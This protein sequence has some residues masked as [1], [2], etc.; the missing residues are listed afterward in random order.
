MNLRPTWQCFGTDNDLQHP[1]EVAVV[2]PTVGRDTILDAV[3]SVYAQRGVSRI[4]LL[5]GVDVAQGDFMRLQE[6]LEAAPTHVTPCLFSPGYSTSSRH[7]GLHPAHDGGT[8]RTV[9]SYLANARHVAYLDDDN[10]WAPNHLR[11]MLDAIR[12]RDWAFALRWFVHPESRQP[13]CVDDWESVGPDR[14]DYAPRFGGW[15]DPN[16]L[17]ID[18]LACEPVLRWWDVPLPGDQSQLSSDRHVFDWLRRKGAPG[19][20]GQPTVYYVMQA[21]DGM[22]P[23]RLAHMGSRY[24]EAGIGTQR[25][26][27]PRL[28]MIT[29]CKGRLRHLQQTLP[30]M[31]CQPLTEVVVVDYGCP[32]GTAAW[33]RANFPAVR[34]VEVTDDPGF[35][36]SRARNI[37]ARTAMTPWLLFVD[38]DVIVGA[39]LGEWIRA[40]LVPGNF[41]LTQ[42]FGRSDLSG[43]FFCP[44]KAFEAVGG[45]DEAITGWGGED[46][47]LYIRLKTSGCLLNS[48][49]DG[50]F[51]AISHGD[52]ERLAYTSA[53]RQ[54][55]HVIQHWYSSMKYDLTALW[56]REPTLNERTK[57][58]RLAEGAVRKA[59]DGELDT[60]EVFLQLGENT[61]ATRLAVLKLERRLIYKLAP[62]EEGT[63]L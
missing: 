56:G 45:Y 38:A 34:V 51:T 50:L 58:R 28:T 33:V 1:F 63:S 26:E 18:K 22:H 39:E 40:G 55:L 17:M 4:Q 61:A 35:N 23:F 16:C 8:L 43:S 10:W 42:A 2:M 9:L 53:G 30:L 29:T 3:D 24:P 20:T 60:T 12:G 27:S 19:E 44:R 25:L 57:L 14:G 36:L 31:V 48:Y 47:D 59:L 62:R 15:V 41:Y 49:P 46:E 21:G 32:Q 6:L 5:I 52:D 13:V 54:E 7:A 37:G 11:S